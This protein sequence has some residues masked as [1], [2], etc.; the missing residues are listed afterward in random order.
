[1][2]LLKVKNLNAFY[3]NSQ[4][5]FN[6]NLDITKNVALTR[7]QCD[8]NFLTNIDTSK[9]IVLNE[10]FCGDNLITSLK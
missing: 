5:L 1:M 2:T 6:M 3:G 10:L 9:N 7:L 8:Y 4:V